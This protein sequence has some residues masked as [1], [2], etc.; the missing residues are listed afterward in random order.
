MVRKQKISGFLSGFAQGR[1]GSIAT[2]GGLTLGVAAASVGLS[3]TIAQTYETR[4][5]MQRGLDAALLSVAR[6]DDYDQPQAL[7]QDFMEAFAAQRK[8]VKDM[9]VT[10]HY[11][12]E[13]GLIKGDL[14]FRVSTVLPVPGLSSQGFRPHIAAEV[15]PPGARRL[16]I[17]LSLD[18]SG[19]MNEPMLGGGTRLEALQTSLNQIFTE[20]GSQTTE[21]GSSIYV[22]IVPYASSVN[23]GNLKGVTNATS[24]GGRSKS[25]ANPAPHAFFGSKRTRTQYLSDYYA[26]ST[27][28]WGTVSTASEGTT[29]ASTSWAETQLYNSSPYLARGLWAV[30]ETGTRLAKEAP[31]D[32]TK[33][34]F[35]TYEDIRQFRKDRRAYT[36]SQRVFH[37]TWVTPVM[38][39]LPMTND[40]A[41]MRNYAN[42][43]VAYGGTAGH[44][45]MEWAWRTI[46]P[47]WGGAWA[48]KPTDAQGRFNAVTTILSAQVVA[49][50]L[51]GV[52][53]LLNQT[54]GSVLGILGLG[55][56]GGSTDYVTADRLPTNYGAFNTAKTII[57]MTDGAFSPV[58]DYN[59]SADSALRNSASWSKIE[60]SAIDACQQSAN[61]HQTTWSSTIR[62][63]ARTDCQAAFAYFE[64][65]CNAVKAKGVRVYTI[66]FTDDSNG[67]LNSLR[68]CATD[69]DKVFSV[70]TGAQLT[71]A[72]TRIFR[73]TN[74]LR[75]SR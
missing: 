36:N 24:V 46:S 25:N 61:L 45:G 17:A 30:E 26:V 5:E 14:R 74:A 7:V 1:R 22:S 70:G 10:A 11:D 38:H 65:V 20:I 23:I 72:F 43:M 71:S 29:T 47:Q 49:D 13:T 21:H 12:H 6:S 35:G 48:T 53:D 15:T 52:G 33:V 31:P 69:P 16:E 59:A 44:L 68:R 60:S 37:K 50:L 67:S 51:A 56:G 66:A 32:A 75:V 28:A 18:M 9:V 55:G 8:L 62:S 19:S 73:E 64:E 27:D 58:V 3:M 57:M 34:K 2:I 39:V 41:Q 63:N 4:A 40:V 42:N 54:V